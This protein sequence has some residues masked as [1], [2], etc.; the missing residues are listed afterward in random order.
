MGFSLFTQQL[1]R[2]KPIAL[3]LLLILIAEP[4][5]AQRLTTKPGSAASLSSRNLRNLS[6]LTQAVGCVKYFYPSTATT[7]IDWQAF[8]VASIPVVSR[9]PTDFV[10][11]A[12][13]DSLLA[14]VA[15]AARLVLVP[16][17]GLGPRVIP[18][19][20]T[21]GYYWEHRSLGGDKEGLGLLRFLLRMAGI[22][23][24]SQ[25]RP[26]SSA[27]LRT[28]LLS[29]Y[30]AQLALTDSLRL[31]L[32]LVH[33]GAAKPTSHAQEHFRAA[34]LTYRSPA[35]RLA[36]VMLSWNVIQQF[37]PYRA[38]LAQ[39]DWPRQLQW[40]LQGASQ[41]NSEAELLAVCRRMLATLHDRHVT[42][43]HRSTTNLHVSTRQLDVGFYLVDNRVLVAHT[44]PQLAAQFPLGAEL[45]HVNN[46][47]V[48][49]LLDSIQLQTPA[50]SPGQ[51]R[52]LAA[53]GLLPHLA[54]QTR[55]ATFLLRT[56]DGN[57]LAVDTRFAQLKSRFRRVAA[58]RLVAPGI[59]YLDAS[60]ISYKQF[61]QQ[62]A[63]LQAAQG[64]IVD[65][66]KRPTYDMRA[67]M[68]HFSATALKGDVTAT[69]ILSKPDFADARYDSAQGSSSA[70]L[71]LLRM[72]KVFLVG[73][74]T[75]SY[76]E[77]LTEQ[78][79]HYRL[80]TLL[81]QPTGGTNGELNFASI[82]KDLL[83]SWTGRRVIN[84]DQQP[85]Q[86]QG[87]APA[88]TVEPTA[89]Q[90]Q[91]GQDAALERALHYLQASR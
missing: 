34:R 85:Y 32:P 72:P 87:I 24:S 84:R 91:Q 41:S 86:G 79:R 27:T 14:P 52:Q 11:R 22:G 6:A 58:V 39:A 82:G 45:T 77:T 51:A 9:A 88:I 46:R 31:I 50:T 18:I 13:L 49:A 61:S 3:L 33:W 76:G 1:V 55:R 83:L 66:R 40:A 15:P 56:T 64:L 57:S 48:A 78:V 74:D 75:Y 47:P 12:T 53:A 62:L 81:G 21:T 2:L 63:S 69:P 70:R 71:P 8:L 10:L 73:A 17:A 38:Q 90:V 7:T 26:A 36:I 19:D 5:Q 65:F 43:T 54:Q 60:W 35:Y 44:S 42:L 59:Y 25:L 80:G 30:E 37:Y 67:I 89:T 29:N 20:T 68:Q 28:A 23:Y 4:V 16:L